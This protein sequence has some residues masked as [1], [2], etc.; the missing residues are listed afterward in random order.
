MRGV[1]QAEQRDA[2]LKREAR[3]GIVAAEGPK[4][5]V[6]LPIS[7]MRERI[8]EMVASNQV[9]VVT[10][11][12]GCGKT[13]QVPQ[14]ILHAN[15]EARIVVAQPR[16]LAAIGAADRVSRE[17][18]EAT[19]GRIGYQVRLDR[20]DSSHTRCLFCTVGIVLRRLQSDPSLAGTT[21]LIIDEVHERAVLTDFL[22]A[23]VR[24][25]LPT[26]PLKLILMSATL[27]AG[28]FDEYFRDYT[29]PAALGTAAQVP[30]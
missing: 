19:G 27:E 2:G 20:E 13:T 11:A 17:L 29:L 6:D 15:P 16:R 10:G 14:Y 1:E 28:P 8:V 18:G 4:P 3:G 25:I 26:R 7:E 24:D 21:H 23:I 22:L 5:V 9:S 12:T 30:F